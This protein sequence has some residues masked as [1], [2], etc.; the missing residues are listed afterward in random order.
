MTM[1]QKDCREEG[2]GWGESSTY[3]L[4]HGNIFKSIFTLG[5]SASFCLPVIQDAFTSFPKTA[6]WKRRTHASIQEQV[7]FK[8]NAP[9]LNSE[10][11]KYSAYHVHRP[12][13]S[14]FT[15]SVLCIIVSSCCPFKCGLAVQAQISLTTD[16]LLT[17]HHTEVILEAKCTSKAFFSC[18]VS[19]Q[20]WFH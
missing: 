8:R 15:S 19:R 20:R 1:W 17:G 2:A 11:I 14:S 10:R 13:Y 6:Y 16:Q 18:L 12:Y 7:Q 4:H 9:N 3:Q 5:L